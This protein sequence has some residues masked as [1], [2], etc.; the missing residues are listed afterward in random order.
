MTLTEFF[1]TLTA[2]NPLRSFVWYAA[3][4]YVI[5]TVAG[6][7]L[8]FIA[9]K[10]FHKKK[11]IDQSENAFVEKLIKAW[12]ED[13][14]NYNTKK[15]YKVYNIS[16][17][18][19]WLDFKTMKY[20]LSSSLHPL[21]TCMVN[22]QL[23]N[24][25]FFQFVTRINDGGFKFDKGFYLIDD[26]QK[27]YISSSKMWAFDYHEELCFP[28]RRTINVTDIK[29]DLYESNEVELETAVNPVSLQKF[30]EST[31]IQKLLAG[32]ELEDAM[33][34]MKMLSIIT[35]VVVSISL[36]ILLKIAGLFGGKI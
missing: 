3:Y 30:M 23:T 20:K 11:V 31:V 19:N 24:G 27:Y 26:L 2:S 5:T 22:M 1:S 15:L 6:L 29:K 7:G 9:Y 35:L 8:V 36:L 18:K 34:M 10:M 12:R 32:A 14:T 16:K 21:S 4:S 13:G 25:T 28:I 17:L 33:R